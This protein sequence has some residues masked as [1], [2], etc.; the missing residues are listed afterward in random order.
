[1]AVNR[2]TEPWVGGRPVGRQVTAAAALLPLAREGD[3]GRSVGGGSLN[4]LGARP[5]L[6]MS[7]R[8]Q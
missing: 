4:V 8:I 2:R 1:M 7:R 5:P 3:G 6:A